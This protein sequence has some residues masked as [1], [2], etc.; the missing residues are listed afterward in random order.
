MVGQVPVLSSAIRGRPSAFEQSFFAELLDGGAD[1]RVGEPQL[2][3]ELCLVQAVGWCLQTGPEQPDLRIAHALLRELLAEGLAQSTATD[4]DLFDQFR[5]TDRQRR[6][7]LG[8]GGIKLPISHEESS[9]TFVGERVPARKFR[10]RK[11]LPLIEVRLV[12]F[13][14]I[15]PDL[16]HRLA[17]RRKWFH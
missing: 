7:G 13:E 8:W 5:P 10:C 12:P 9:E 11:I 3:R 17:A 14:T 15:V 16:R 4:G 1:L 6:E 2:R